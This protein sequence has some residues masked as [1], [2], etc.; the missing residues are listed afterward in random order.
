MRRNAAAMGIVKIGREQYPRIQIVTAEE[1]IN[2][3]HPVLPRAIE[4]D[5]FRQPLRPPRPVKIA[6]Q[7]PQLSI[8][9]PI[10]GGKRRPDVQDHLSGKVLGQIAASV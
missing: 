2:G 9:L 8:P 5:A 3:P 1:L 7:E 10:P 4:S 6:T